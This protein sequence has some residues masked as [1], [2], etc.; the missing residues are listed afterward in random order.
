MRNTASLAA[1]GIGG[2]L[3][4][5]P[6][7]AHHSFSAEFDVNKPLTLT[8]TVT[9]VEWQN[10]HTWFYIDVKDEAG[11]VTNWGLELASPNLLMRNG[12]TRNTMNVGDVVTVESYQA[13]N[14]SNIA[15][16]RTITLTATGKK[17]L[18]GSSASRTTP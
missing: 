11:N 16:A 17:L 10:P 3:L 2:L 1:A 7:L 8:G 6:A 14:G 12:W 5:A 13:K 9:S 18:G 15:N 4:A